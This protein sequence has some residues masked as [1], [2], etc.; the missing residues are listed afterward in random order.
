MASLRGE[1]G[2]GLPQEDMWVSEGHEGH[3]E[4]TLMQLPTYTPPSSLWSDGPPLPPTLLIGSCPSHHVEG[5]LTTHRGTWH[6]TQS[7]HNA[8]KALEVC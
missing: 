4:G 1:R 2:W 3:E 6:A 8:H 5:L 7:R